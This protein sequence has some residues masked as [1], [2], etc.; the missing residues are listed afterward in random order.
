MSTFLDPLGDREAFVPV[1]SIACHTEGIHVRRI[2]IRMT[3]YE[4]EKDNS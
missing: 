3:S 4:N 2:Y 1:S